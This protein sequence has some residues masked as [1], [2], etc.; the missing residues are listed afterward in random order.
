MSM[1]PPILP[2]NTTEI[3]DLPLA[4]K[5][6]ENLDFNVYNTNTSRPANSTVGKNKSLDETYSA[7]RMFENY[8]FPS[9]VSHRLQKTIKY[10]IKSIKRQFTEK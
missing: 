4:K 6:N 7:E 9:V 8:F 3:Q 2:T 1:A 5:V 10:N